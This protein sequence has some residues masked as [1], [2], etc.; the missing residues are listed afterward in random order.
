M[1][2]LLTVKINYCNKI[3]NREHVLEN[4]IDFGFKRA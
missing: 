2:M 4:K 3:V 1:N